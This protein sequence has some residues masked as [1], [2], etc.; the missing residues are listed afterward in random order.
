VIA[1]AAELAFQRRK[2]VHVVIALTH[3]PPG[4]NEKVYRQFARY[5]VPIWTLEGSFSEHEMS[6]IYSS[7]NAYVSASRGEG[8]N[9]PAAEAAACGLPVVLPDNT[10]HP[11]I[12]GPEAFLF[13]PDG[14]KTYPEGDWISDWYVGQ[15]F[16]RFGK[17]SIRRL[18]EILEI[19]SRDGPGVRERAAALRS[20]IVGRYTW[21]AAAA[22]VVERL[23]EVQP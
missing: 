7:S 19:V 5:K 2:N 1:E 6:R 10:A 22:R 4:W 12:F 15:L 3:S 11:E 16:S 17:P 8:F 21:D 14:L 23:L 18:T 9:L 13:K 20:K